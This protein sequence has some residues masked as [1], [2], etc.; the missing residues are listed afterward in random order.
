MTN[1][2]GKRYEC[3]KCGSQM[4]VTKGGEGSLIC[5]GES[6]VQK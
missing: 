6:M 4:I 3:G 1:V 2:A 5:C